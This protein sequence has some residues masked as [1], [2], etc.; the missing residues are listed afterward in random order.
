[1][2]NVRTSY[3]QNEVPVFSTY[4]EYH[5]MVI[6]VRVFLVVMLFTCGLHKMQDALHHFSKHSWKSTGLQALIQQMLEQYT[7]LDGNLSH[8]S[9]MKTSFILASTFTKKEKKRKKG[10]YHA[11]KFVL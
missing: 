4:E 7:F 6:Q 8:L 3:E 5:R 10:R 2:L 11:L 1:M 9:H